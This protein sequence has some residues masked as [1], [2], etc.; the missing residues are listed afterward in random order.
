MVKDTVKCET[1]LWNRT[2]ES[3][4]DVPEDAASGIFYKGCPHCFDDVGLRDIEEES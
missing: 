2:D 4:V 1:C 3:L